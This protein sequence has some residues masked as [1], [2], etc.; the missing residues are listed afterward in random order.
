MFSVRTQAISNL[1]LQATGTQ[2]R[3]ETDLSFGRYF[4][5]TTVFIGK[6]ITSDLFIQGMFA[7]RY[8]DQITELN[9]QGLKFE[10]DIGI[11]LRSPLFDIRWNIVP[12]H[13]ES[14]FIPD[15]TF[16]ILWRK[17]F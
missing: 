1:V 6:Y 9:G 7:L 2:I 12:S 8:N 13:P 16:T 15:N 17:S 3:Q 5:N 14:L 11:E 4:D 10:P